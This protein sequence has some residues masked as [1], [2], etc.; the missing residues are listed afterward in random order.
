MSLHMLWI[1]GTRCRPDWALRVKPC[2]VQ[3]DAFRDLERRWQYGYDESIASK[4]PVLRARP[5]QYVWQ[6]GG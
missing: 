4:M 2:W 6:D 1:P 5:S 3:Q